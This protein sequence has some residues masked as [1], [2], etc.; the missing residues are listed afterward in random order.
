[1]QT[2][3]KKFESSVKNPRCRLR[4]E[5]YHIL[6]VIGR[7][8]ARCVLATG[9]TTPWSSSLLYWNCRWKQCTAT[10]FNIFKAGMSRGLPAPFF[11]SVKRS[12]KPA[13]YEQ[14]RLWV[15]RLLQKAEFEKELEDLQ[16]DRL[17]TKRLLKLNPFIDQE[18][19]LRVGCDAEIFNDHKHPLLLSGDHHNTMDDSTS[20]IQ[21]SLRRRYWIIKDQ[22]VIHNELRRCIPCIKHNVRRNQQLMGRPNI[23]LVKLFNTAAWTMRALSEQ[24]CRKDD[25]QVPW[26]GMY[27]TLCVWSVCC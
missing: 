25:L 6:R 11:Y 7:S 27:V 16:K 24:R 14:A 18:A 26:R 5:R 22:K 10:I 8:V 17:N 23:D 19:M 21:N 1:M 20:T 9:R 3:S 15:L 13:E 2:G 4:F 12:N